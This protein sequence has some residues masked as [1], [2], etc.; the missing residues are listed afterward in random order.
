MK[1]EVLKFIYENFKDKRKILKPKLNLYL[2][3]PEKSIRF[4]NEFRN[5]IKCNF[6]FESYNSIKNYRKNNEFGDICDI[7]TFVLNEELKG[8]FDNLE[9]NRLGLSLDEYLKSGKEL[10]ICKVWINWFIDVCFV[11]NIYQKNTKTIQEDRVLTNLTLYEE[12]LY[13]D[14]LDILK[15]QNC[16]IL[17][18]PLLKE[19][20]NGIQT[21]CQ[22]NPTIFQCLFSDIIYPTSNTKKIR[23]K[24]GDIEVI[25]IENYNSNLEPLKKEIMF[26]NG[27]YNAYRIDFDNKNKIIA[28][29]NNKEIYKEDYNYGD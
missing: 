1:E 6:G 21:D 19:K 24:I 13:N 3:N 27:N 29:L 4:E 10:H 22:K 12:K 9:M 5:K 20:I 2:K 7:W 18:F 15:N 28:V 14:I 26:G 8:Q 25:L 16:T 11:Q 23:K 17:S